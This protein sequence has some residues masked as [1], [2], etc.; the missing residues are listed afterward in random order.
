MVWRERVIISDTIIKNTM[1]AHEY[2][3]FGYSSNPGMKL[4]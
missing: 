4:R 3:T 2:K 1:T